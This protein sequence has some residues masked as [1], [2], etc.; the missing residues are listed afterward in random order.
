[1]KETGILI[2]KERERI[3]ALENALNERAAALPEKQQNLVLPISFM[4]YVFL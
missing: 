4:K 1:M 3:K 2:S